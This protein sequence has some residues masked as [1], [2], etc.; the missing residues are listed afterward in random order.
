MPRLGRAPSNHVHQNIGGGE[1]SKSRSESEVA[2][3]GDV[4][5]TGNGGHVANNTTTGYSHQ[6]QYG[7]LVP[8]STNIAVL[9]INSSNPRHPLTDEYYY[10]PDM[11]CMV[12]N[13]GVAR[14][15]TA[16]YQFE[17]VYAHDQ[18]ING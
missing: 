4:E 2:N 14:G 17:P 3:N 13:Y 15:S 1:G 6:Q 5:N 8:H 10:Y 7:A 18:V 16:G 9:G 12:Q 11:D